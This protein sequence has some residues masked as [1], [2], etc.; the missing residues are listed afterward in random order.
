MTMKKTPL[1]FL[2]LTA[3]LSLWSCRQ[4]TLSVETETTIPVKAPEL[5]PKAIQEFVTAT[6]TAFPIRDVE[7]KTEQAGRYL[8]KVN[9]RTGQAFRMKDGVRKDEILISLENPEYVNQVAFESKKLQHE[10]AQREYTKQQGVY[11]KGGI[12]LKELSDAQKAF[13]DATY[14]FENAS[15]ALKKLEVRAPFDGV[16]VDL[17]H[18]T[19]GQWIDANTPV[20]RIMDYSRLYADLTL[21][22][23]EMDRLAQGQRV[24]VT[25]YSQP[26][27]SLAGVVNQISPA[28]DAESRMF[29][30]RVEIPNPDLHLKPG[31]FIKTDIV[32][33]EKASALVIPKSI[34]L[35]RRGAKTVFVVER[36]IALERRIQ[37][38][39]ENVDEAEVTS[40]LKPA[41]R[42]VTEGFETLRA[43]ARVKII[44]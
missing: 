8:L 14:A 32:V 12:T 4:E 16:I 33:Q 26:N 37:T 11:D 38:G 24:I 13:V 6:G 20:I 34:I 21:P 3:L 17:P 15:L 44:E 19:D 35:D 7:L 2:G 36:G 1:I 41:D 27:I 5:Q 23:K 39:I 10:S 9:V 40:G 43:N 22:G 31:S 30:L 25:D 42:V 18:F 29:K 28:L